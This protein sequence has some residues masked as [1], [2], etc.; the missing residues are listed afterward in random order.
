MSKAIASK[1]P[2]ELFMGYLD[3]VNKS[4]YEHESTPVVGNLLSLMKKIGEGK[5][6]GAAIYKTDPNEPFDYFTVRMS[7]GKVELDSRGKDDP[8]IDFKVAQD[9]LVEV[10]EHP[11]EYVNNPAKLD[12]DWLKSRLVA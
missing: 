12:L 10:N 7:G 8:D 6:F 5:K 4:L 1:D 11:R 3:V 2:Y 9:F